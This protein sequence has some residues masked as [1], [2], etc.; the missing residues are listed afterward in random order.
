MGN[1]RVR[2]ARWACLGMLLWMPAVASALE[3]VATI[4]PWHSLT[5]AVM[6]GVGTPALLIRGSGSPHTYTLRPSDAR[7]LERADLVVWGGEGLETLLTRPLAS[8][9][10]KGDKLALLGVD[11]LTRLPVR[12]GGAWEEEGDDHGHGHDH[13]ATDPHLWLDPV[14]ARLMALAIAERLARLDPGN[15]ARYRANAA[16]LSDRLEALDRELASEMA[17]LRERPYIVFHDAYHYFEHR[18]GL[19]AVGAVV[20]HPDRPPGARRV[21]EIVRRM[22]ESKAVCLFSEPQFPSRLIAT[23]TE[24]QPVRVGRLDPLGAGLPEGPEHYFQTLRNLAR[25]FRECLAP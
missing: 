16:G 8:L 4:P 18:Y 10:R 13:A 9:A 21:G 14:N 25:S 6:A 17:A 24:H 1:Q 20:V 3:V 23:V 2:R 5:A 11:G 15:A 19:H 12:A 22:R 7:L